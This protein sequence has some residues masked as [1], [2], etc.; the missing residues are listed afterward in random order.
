MK[1][2]MLILVAALVMALG[3]CPAQASAEPLKLVAAHVLDAEHPVHLGFIEMD[4]LLKEKTGGQITLDIFPNSQ[5]GDEDSVMNALRVGGGIDLSAPS[6]APLQAYSSA[7][8]VCDF[9]YAFT[10]YDQ[11]WAFYDGEMGKYLYSTLDGTGIKGL[12]WWDNGFRNFTTTNKEIHTPADL[13]GMKIRTMNAPVHMAYVNALGAAATPI[14]FGELYSALQQGV[15]DGEE[16]PVANIFG[17]KFYEVQK[18][19]IMDRHVHDPSPLL[20]SLKSWDKLTAE[21]KEIVQQA[22]TEAGIYMRQ[23]SVELEEGTLKKLAESGM[24]V[25][26]LTPEQAVMF[27]D[28]T[29]DVYKQF[30]NEA[31]QEAV[32]LYLKALE[33]VRK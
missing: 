14:P 8:L 21:Q 4:R 16:N 18:Y 15:V 31:G 5:L 2:K 33:A 22:A 12:A 7:F 19:L 27:R 26:H 6:A 28:V 17:S 10:N 30:I 29:K 1:G 20:I 3:L 23:K 9:P 32:D 13:K 25:I 24:T 11:V